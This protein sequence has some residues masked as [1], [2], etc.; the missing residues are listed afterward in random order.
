MYQ[1]TTFLNIAWHLWCSCDCHSIALLALSY[2]AYAYA[3]ATQVQVA[4]DSPP[5]AATTY[6]Y[7]RHDTVSVKNI[8]YYN[9]MVRPICFQFSLQM[10]RTK[11]ERK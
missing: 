7:Q 4:Y 8:F 5:T 10:Y 11:Q 9:K 2:L 3:Y 1:R 6:F